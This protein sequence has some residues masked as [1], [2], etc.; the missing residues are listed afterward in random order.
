MDNLTSA[1]QLNQPGSAHR[2]TALTEIYALL[3]HYSY[4]ARDHL[5]WDKLGET[6]CSDAKV[7]LAN[8]KI[9]PH[10]EMRTLVPPDKQPTYMRHHI[11]AIDVHFTNDQ[12]AVVNTQWFA[13]TGL[14]SRD[15]WGEWE[16]TLTLDNSGAWLISEK[17]IKFE[18]MDPNGVAATMASK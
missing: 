9:I 8:G 3:N 4:L 12:E 13:S 7:H 10:S 15:H 16:D 5:D 1:T 18:G 2:V 14:S 11:T 17:K 6:F